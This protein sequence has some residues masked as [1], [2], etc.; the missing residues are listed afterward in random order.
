MSAET[1]RELGEIRHPSAGT[2]LR[3]RAKAMLGRGS[4]GR[5]LVFWPAGLLMLGLL[6]AG[7]DL[8]VKDYLSF[9]FQQGMPVQHPDDAL[10]GEVLL[11]L[12]ESTVIKNAIGEDTVKESVFNE[13]IVKGDNRQRN[14]GESGNINGERS[15]SINPE[16]AEYKKGADRILDYLRHCRR[17]RYG[18]IVY[19]QQSNNDCIFADGVGQTVLFLSHYAGL[20]GENCSNEASGKRTGHDIHDEENDAGYALREAQRQLGNFLRYGMDERSGLPYHGYDAES[21]EKRGIIGWGRAVGWLLMGISEYLKADSLLMPRN[22]AVADEKELS[23]KAELSDA[24][25][26][27]EAIKG[28]SGISDEGKEAPTEKI[29][30]MISACGARIRPDGLFSWQLDCMDGSADTSATGMIFWA[31]DRMRDRG[32]KNSS[33]ISIWEEPGGRLPHDDRTESELLTAETH[34][35]AGLLQYIDEDGKV[36]QASAECV[37]FGEYRQQYGNYPWGQ[38]A[39]LMFLAKYYRENT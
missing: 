13:G 23:R 28:G 32:K 29:R 27:P 14:H 21:G 8:E 12:Y 22:R 33:M 20:F 2:V 3:N 16:A 19:G 11:R 35:A 17:D 36:L 26:I 18:S 1:V 6:E 10:T 24:A 15:G 34:A 38:G 30:R 5:D 25:G 31:I 37:D 7:H 9:W 4:A 39:A